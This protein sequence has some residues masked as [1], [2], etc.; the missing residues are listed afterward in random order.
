[1][2]SISP[3]GA[4]AISWLRGGL[5]K[6]FSFFALALNLAENVEQERKRQR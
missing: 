5:L 2:A 4:K 3:V 1:M 6:L